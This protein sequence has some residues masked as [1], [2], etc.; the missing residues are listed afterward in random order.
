MSGG[1]A[2]LTPQLSGA[3]RSSE[4]RR[5]HGGREGEH[6]GVQPEPGRAVVKVQRLVS[7]S[8]VGV[9]S[10]RVVGA[11]DAPSKGKSEKRNCQ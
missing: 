3:V 6:R 1:T 9:V 7:C 4:H 8:T 2:D 11:T 5:G 10:L